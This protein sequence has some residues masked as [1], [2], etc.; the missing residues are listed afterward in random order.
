[1]RHF[2]SRHMSISG[3]SQLLLTRCWWN[4]TG[5]FLGTSRTDSNCH[6]DICTGNASLRRI[7]PPN[8][9]LTG[10]MD[11]SPGRYPPNNASLPTIPPPNPSLTKRSLIDIPLLPSP[12]LNT[13]QRIPSFIKNDRMK[14]LK[15]KKINDY[16]VEKLKIPT[17]SKNIPLQSL[18]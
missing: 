12:P 9:S 8:I 10:C 15:N 4:F 13:S 18:P 2:S 1:M 11:S 5:R 7:P 14:N 3:I 16:M 17:I 6:S